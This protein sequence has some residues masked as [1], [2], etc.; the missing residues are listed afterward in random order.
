MKHA[1]A[2]MVLFWMCCA[3]FVQVQ[4]LPGALPAQLVQPENGQV[5]WLLDADSSAN[6]AADKWED[7]KYFPRS[8]IKG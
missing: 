8:T 7:Q 1:R 5:K 6:L 3:L 2:F 4:S